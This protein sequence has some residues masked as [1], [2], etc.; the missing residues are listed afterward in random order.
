MAHLGAPQWVIVDCRY[1][2]SEPLAGHNAF[3]SS[4]IPGACY[5]DLEKDLSGPRSTDSVSSGRNPLPDPATFAQ[6]LSRWGISPATQVVVYDDSFGSIAARLWWLLRVSGH[7]SV[8]LLDGGWPVWKRK[9]GAIEDTQPT[10][11][12]PVSSPYPVVVAKDR[13]VDA[14]FVESIR[15]DAAWALLDARPEERFTGERETVDP[16]AG[17]IPGSRHWTFEDNLAF[18]GCFMSP[19]EL[20]EHY[21]AV[22]QQRKTE[23]IV[24]TC[25]SGVTACHNI[26]AM[27]HAGL[28]GSKLYAGSWSDWITDPSRPVARGLD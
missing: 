25:G 4:R 10:S 18:N 2:L 16:V 26:L 13:L 28:E 3:L 14:A 7:R 12:T 17:H 1:T 5:A 24:H 8:A 19:E 22:I 21:A 11:P 23:N 9:K 6:T 20:R 27:E 15:L